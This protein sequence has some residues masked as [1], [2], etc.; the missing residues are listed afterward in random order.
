MMSLRLRFLLASTFLVIAP[1]SAETQ[2]KNVLLIVSDDLKASSLGCY[3]NTICK[4]PNLDRLAKRGMVFER[5]YCQGTWCAPSRLSFM[6]SRYEGSKGKNMGEHFRANG[7]HSARVGKIYHM[8]VPGDIIA[9]TDGNDIP[10]TWDEK[11]NTKGQEAHTPGD[12]AC[13]NL[14]I[15]T[16]ELEGRQSTRMPHRMFV[17]VEYEGDGSDQPD[18]QAANKTIALLKEHKEK[19]FF[20]ATGFVRPHYPSV[21]PTQYFQKYP[22]DKMPLPNVL[23]GDLNDIPNSGLGKTTSQKSGIAKWPSNIQRMWSAYYA[24]VTYMDEQLGKVLDE[25]DRL[26]LTDST[27]IV[28][29]SDHG[30]HL[31]EHHF[32][33]KSNLHEE[34]TRV[35]M[36]IS[37][38]GMK[39]GRTNSVTELMDIYPTLSSLLGIPA[40]ESVQGKNLVPVLKNPETKIRKAALSFNRG[41]HGLRTDRWA[42]LRYKNGDD[43]LYDMEKDPE[44][45]HNLTKK[46][47]FAAIRN[48]MQSLLKERLKDAK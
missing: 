17:S 34:V 25:L 43:E 16:K 28:F 36:I 1:A 18:W 31:G 6:H 20:I 4:T 30:Y 33:Q 10:S 37:V 42:Y 19:P 7:I 21:A 46:K 9:G 8:R 14:N 22:F 44:Q 32:W 41:G 13:L 5:T 48:E 15:F 47:E 38:P 24:T 29:I 12:Y 26:K 35:P 27:A 23:E 40:P 45:F 11:F 39:P 3:G 2:I